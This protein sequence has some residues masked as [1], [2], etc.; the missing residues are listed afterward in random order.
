MDE[1]LQ[2]VTSGTESNGYGVHRDANMLEESMKGMGTKDE[3]L[4][5]SVP[6]GLAGAHS[7]TFNSLLHH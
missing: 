1:A 6:F 2:F 7:D 5:A 4:S 3:H